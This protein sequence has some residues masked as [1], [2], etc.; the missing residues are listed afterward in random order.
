VFV[1]AAVRR[2]LGLKSQT[3]AS[4]TFKGPVTRT[5]SGQPQEGL[6][7]LRIPASFARA[8]K[9]KHVIGMT[10]SITG[11]ATYEVYD[12]GNSTAPT[13]PIDAAHPAVHTQNLD[14]LQESLPPSSR[15]N[16]Y[17]CP[18]F[19]NSLI[20]SVRSGPHPCPNP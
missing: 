20:T 12:C 10:V 6:Y 18:M 1:P 9:A 8:A 14:A 16:G 3:F 4:G 15:Y 11:T 17:G 19:G 5:I 7:L 13:C 2:Y